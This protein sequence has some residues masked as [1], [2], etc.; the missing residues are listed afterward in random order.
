MEKMVKEM[1]PMQALTVPPFILISRA[2][3]CSTE[4]DVVPKAYSEHRVSY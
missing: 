2:I 1:T 4:Y 3:A